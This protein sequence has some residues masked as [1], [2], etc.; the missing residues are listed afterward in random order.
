MLFRSL[1]IIG[2]IITVVLYVLR[3]PAAVFL[4]IVITAIVGI[5]WRLILES[6]GNIVAGSALDLGLP[7]IPEKVI[8]LPDAPNFGAFVE[9]FGSYEWGS[10]ESIFTFFIVTFTLLF[11]DFFDTAGTLVSVGERC[12]LLDDEGQLKDSSKALAA[13]ASATVVGA[14][15]GTSSTTSYVES[16]SG[17]EVGGRTG[18]TAVFVGIFFIIALFFSPILS[19]VTSSVTAPALIFVGILMATQ[20]GKINWS[21]I[22]IAIPAFIT[23]LIMPLAYSIATGIACGFILYPIAMICAKKGK[24]VSVTMYILSLVF[25]A[26]FILTTIW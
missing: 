2:L 1:A 19:V 14:V 7:G 5:F 4:G 23:I 15:V 22:A 21:D 8:S 16:L 20:L 3:V 9:G 13:D 24:K 12:G 25:L 18:L 11:L 10:F 17:V 6:G 26:Y